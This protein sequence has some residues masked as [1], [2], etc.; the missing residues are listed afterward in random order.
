LTALKK[1]TIIF[2]GTARQAIR[3]FPQNL[4]V[5][6]TLALAGLGPDRT[7][8]RV[9]ADPKISGNVHEVEVVGEAGRIVTRIENRAMRQ[10]PKTSLLAAF[11]VMATLR[12][13]VESVKV[14][15]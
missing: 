5:A 13:I 15:T 1:P 8:V 10:N 12:E 4:N 9:I 7:R 14:G 3:G 6:A 2:Q 11:S